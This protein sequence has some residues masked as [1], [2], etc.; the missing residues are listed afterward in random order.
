MEITFAEVVEK[1]EAL[2]FEEKETLVKILKNRL[3][4]A[5]LLRI[6]KA[7]EESRREF[8]EGK[9][10]PMSIKDIMKEVSS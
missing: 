2:S 7:V 8:R 1:V 9:L 10:K 3:H 4:E 5:E 6:E